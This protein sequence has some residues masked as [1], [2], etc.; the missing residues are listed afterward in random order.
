MD[1]PVKPAEYV[2]W[3]WHLW[4]IT[5]KAYGVPAWQLLGGRYRS[6]VRLYADTPTGKDKEDQIEK[7][8]YRIKEQGYTWLK[9][10]LSIRSLRGKP[11]TLVN[12]RILERRTVGHKEL[13]GIWQCQAPFYP[14]SDHR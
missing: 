3:R 8:R 1:R 7:V 5:G 12:E 4:D 14:D 11:G 6:S 13:Y 9:M 2:Q 10:D